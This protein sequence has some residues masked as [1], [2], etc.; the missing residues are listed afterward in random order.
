MMSREGHT[1]ETELAGQRSDDNRTLTL[2]GAAL[3]LDPRKDAIQRAQATLKRAIPAAPTATVTAVA[4][5]GR[6]VRMADGPP[7]PESMTS[8][9][10]RCG[11]S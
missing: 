7:T 11:P 3:D 2:R 8:S 5:N 9:L 1:G 10:Q 4:D 6:H